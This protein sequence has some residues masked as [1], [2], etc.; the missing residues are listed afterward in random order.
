MRW[1]KLGQIFVPD[2]NYPWM[3]SH[4]SNPIPVRVSPEIIKVYFSCR[5]SSN[6]A[7]VGYVDLDAQTFE[8]IRISEKPVLGLGDKGAFD[9]HGISLGCLIEE[10]G[11]QYLYYLGWNLAANVPFRNSIGVAT[12]KL[13]EETFTRLFKGPLLDRTIED[14][15]SLSYPFVLKNYK[16]EYLMWYGSHK[17]W[18]NSAN[19]MIHGIKIARSKDL[20]HWDRTS[21]Y[22]LTP[23]VKHY[24]FSRPF[25]QFSNSKYNMWYSFRGNK[26][27]IGYA[28][29]K[30]GRNWTRLD[31]EVGIDVSVKGW[32]SEMICYP[33]ILATPE[34]TLLFYNGNGYGKSGFGVA[35]LVRN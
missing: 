5:D 35:E 30:D 12:K 33:Y 34:R 24:A 18:G 28:Q 6:R 2:N 1:K 3:V 10:S 22:V 8:V 7:S 17:S 32:D 29:S 31:K 9:D 21:E 15:F 27:R 23:T 16:S 26:Y 13:N 20:I 11:T 14:P 19:D 4:A 25:V